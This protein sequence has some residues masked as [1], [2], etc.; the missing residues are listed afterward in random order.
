MM[1]MLNIQ[2]VPAPDDIPEWASLV[3]LPAREGQGEF[4]RAL[5]ADVPPSMYD[6]VTAW[7]DALPHAQRCVQR[8][9]RLTEHGTGLSNT[10]HATIV[11]GLNG[12]P[13][14]SVYGIPKMRAAHAVF[15]VRAALVITY[16]HHR[17]V[18]HGEVALVTVDRAAR[19]NI[20]IEQTP[21]YRFHDG[22]DAVEVVAQRDIPFPAAAVA[23]AREKARDYHCRSAYY[24][25]GRHAS[26]ASGP[27]RI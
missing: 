2:I 10:G 21:L 17:G 12:E 7:L 16:R 24:A 23:A 22:D 13:L 14:P 18:G 3:Q 15:Y 8:T 4:V 20:G 6:R 26:G 9:I 25:L 11:A 5:R 19:H 1:M 27:R